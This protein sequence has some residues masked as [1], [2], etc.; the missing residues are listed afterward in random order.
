MPAAWLRDK[1]G[2]PSTDPRD[3][4]AGGTIPPLGGDAEAG[5]Y[6]GYASG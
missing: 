6:K 2:R 3:F 4:F 5:G 1:H